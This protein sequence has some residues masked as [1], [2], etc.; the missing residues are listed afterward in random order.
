[1][2]IRRHL[3]CHA[4]RW[5]APAVL[6]AVLGLGT[7]AVPGPARAQDSLSRVLVDVAD[8]VLRGGQPY[9]R[10]GGYG[11]DGRLVVGRDRYGRT[12]YYRLADRNRPPYG[13]AYGYYGNGRAGDRGIKCNKHGKCKATY[14]DPRYDRRARMS[15]SWYAGDGRRYSTRGYYR[16]DD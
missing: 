5:A 9:Y 6:T 2:N 16:R 11:P 7:A 8:V 14:Y 3:P 4:T 1:M 15:G 10:H 12:V 13:N